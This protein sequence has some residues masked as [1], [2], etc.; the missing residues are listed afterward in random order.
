M[1]KTLLT[2]AL[3]LVGFAAFSQNTKAHAVKI[4]IPEVMDFTIPQTD[5]EFNYSTANMRN[6][7]D[8]AAKQKELQ[9][10]SNRDWK[11]TVAASSSSFEGDVNPAN[12]I[13]LDV[14]SISVDGTPMGAPVSETEAELVTGD[15]GGYGA[16]TFELSY[17]IALD[18]DDRWNYEPDTYSTTL[19][20][21]LTA[22]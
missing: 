11:I 16:N 7:T 19:T 6:G 22:Q 18:P 10:R 14:L 8:P 12:T 17:A 5:L 20:Y 4:E 15:K 13:P 2:V 21:T 1:K 3:G 9:V